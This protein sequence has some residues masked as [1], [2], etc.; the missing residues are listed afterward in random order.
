MAPPKGDSLSVQDAARV[1][2]VSPKTLL[3]WL[4]EG[5]ISHRLSE[6]GETRL[7]RDDVT[8]LIGPSEPRDR[9][10]DE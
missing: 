6:T 3:R 10:E 7:P 5:R 4:R 2:G 8:R 9:A 1:L